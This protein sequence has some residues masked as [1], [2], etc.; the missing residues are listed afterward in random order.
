MIYGKLELPGA[1]IPRAELAKYLDQELKFKG[2][3]QLVL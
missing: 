1:G 3:K 2:I